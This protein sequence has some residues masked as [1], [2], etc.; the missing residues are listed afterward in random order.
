MG[1]GLKVVRLIW[2]TKEYVIGSFWSD[3][4]N[5]FIKCRGISTLH[6]HKCSIKKHR[7][8]LWGGGGGGHRVPFTAGEVNRV[9]RLSKRREGGRL[10]GTET[11]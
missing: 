8:F 4:R 11:N 2:L 5:S 7:S 3:I 9:K 1:P 6:S 10:F